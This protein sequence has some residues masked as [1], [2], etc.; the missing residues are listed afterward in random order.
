MTVAKQPVVSGDGGIGPVA[1]DTLETKASTL[2]PSLVGMSGVAMV[3]IRFRRSVNIKIG[4]DC[5][6]SFNHN[7]Q[8]FRHLT[9]LSASRSPMLY[10]SAVVGGFGW[11]TAA[12]SR[13]QQLEGVSV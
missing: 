4:C 7:R 5:E 11:L 2:W 1:S 10:C 13:S 3:E 12:L 6:D 8:S 9:I